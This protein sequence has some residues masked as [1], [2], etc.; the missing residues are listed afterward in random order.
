MEEVA[1]ATTACM[2]VTVILTLIG[3]WKMLNRLWLRPKKLEMLL[4]KQGLRGSPYRFLVGDIKEMLKMGKEAQSKPM[5]LSDDIVPRVVS[6]IHQKIN[7]HGKNTFIWFGPTPRVIITDPELV[8]DVFFGYHDYR[9]VSINPL[10]SKLIATG[11]LSHEGEKWLKHRR[12]INPAFNLAKLKVMLPAIFKSCYDMISKWED[13]LSSDGSC[14]MDVWPS[15]Q[16][17]ASDVI[18][19]TAFGS[20]Y[21]DGRRIFQ[22]QK[23]QAELTMKI[24]MKIFIPGWRF[25]PTST[26]RRMKEIDTEIVALLKAMINKR[27]NALKEGEATKNDL[28]GQLLESNRTEIQKHGNNKN[29]GMTLQDVIEEC[30]L[31][32]FAGSESTSALLVWTMVLMSRYLDWQERAREEVLQVF[33]KQ[34]PDFDG[35]SH[36]KI[37]TMILHEVLRLYPPGTVLTRTVHEDRKL[38]DLTLPAGVQVSLPIVLVHHD[39]KLWGDDANEFNPARFSEGISKVTNGKVSFFPFGWGPRICIGQNFAMVEAKM[40]L[41]IILQHFSF[42][43]SPAYA[44]APSVVRTLQPQYGAQLILRKL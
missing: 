41:S 3:V 17:L 12:I 4:R 31:F 30:K 2:V 6:F 39:S 44:H 25:L 13:M 18:A 16:N 37:V 22:L 28:L 32:Y 26:R 11:L 42:E 38:G 10:V 43:L 36:L 19:Q 34:K 24:I 21:E 40:A 9:K 20:N 8:K 7:K 15:L 29:M 35:L 27:E 14:E 33:G 23:E 1:W 5:T